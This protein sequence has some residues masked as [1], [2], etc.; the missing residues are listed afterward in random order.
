MSRGRGNG[1]TVVVAVFLVFFLS[2]HS[3]AGLS[4]E[5]QSV[6]VDRADQDVSFTLDFNKSPD[7]TTTDLF[8]RHADSFQYEIVPNTTRGIDNFAFED[9]RAVIRGDEISPSMI[10]IRDG[11][12]NGS[13]PNPAS[14]GW[15][16]ILGAVPYSLHGNQLSF[17]APFNLLGV[18]NPNGGFAYRVFTTN[19]G[20][21]VS[22]VEG[23]SIPLP[24]ALPAGL[25]VLSMLVGASFVKH[26]I[27]SRRWSGFQSAVVN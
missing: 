22:N 6:S 19:F 5:S 7:F 18:T 23:V 11:F 1:L 17:T 26:R 21:T 13:D 10:P 14:G 27:Q 12:E 15:G 2:G 25:I 16:K 20:A 8:G 9:I 24:A 3:L 4:I